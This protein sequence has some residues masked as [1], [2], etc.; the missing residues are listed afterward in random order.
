MIV[1]FFDICNKRVK[2][3]IIRTCI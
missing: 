1:S 2:R 3:K